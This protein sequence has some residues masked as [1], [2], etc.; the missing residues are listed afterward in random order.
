M[1]VADGA[2]PKYPVGLIQSDAGLASLDKAMEAQ[3]WHDHILR[4]QEAN[5]AITEQFKAAP[6]HY[7]IEIS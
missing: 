1:I 4:S 7:T 2:V 6:I 3:G 5:K